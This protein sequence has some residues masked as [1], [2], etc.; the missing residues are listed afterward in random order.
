MFALEKHFND[1]QLHIHL[2][3]MRRDKAYRIWQLAQLVERDT[4]NPDIIV[5]SAFVDHDMVDETVEAV[6]DSSADEPE[7]GVGQR[8][9]QAN[10]HFQAMTDI[11][12]ARSYLHHQHTGVHPFNC[13]YAD[14]QE[15][16]DQNETHRLAPAQ[17]PT[18]PAPG[19]IL[20]LPLHGLYGPFAIPLP[21]PL[22]G[23]NTDEDS[24]GEGVDF[25]PAVP[26][27]PAR[28]RPN[29][30]HSVWA[31]SIHALRDA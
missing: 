13:P 2:M 11:R 25:G 10:T 31:L 29:H 18:Q 17:A 6:S 15:M 12:G 22:L 19:T 7:Q 3:R 16:A 28:A 20:P 24:D 14:L 5:I 9:N 30:A 21:R 26:Y 8:A 1:A 27:D 4:A 23:L